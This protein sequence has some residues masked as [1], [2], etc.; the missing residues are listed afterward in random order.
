MAK[1]TG[2][3][4][5]RPKVEMAGRRFGL[6]VVVNHAG[7]EPSGEISWLCRCDCGKQFASPGS[8][9]RRGSTVSCGCKRR[10]G[11][12]PVHGGFGTPEYAVWAS[13]KSRCSDPDN[14]DYY[15]RG[16]TVCK[17]WDDSFESFLADMG[18]R[19]S[20]QHSIDRKDN[21]GNYEP[22]NCRWVTRK[23]QERN[24]RSN[25]ILTL[26]GKSQPIVV[27]SEELGIHQKLIACRLRRGWSEKD[28]LTVPLGGPR[29]MF[30]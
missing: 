30:A 1:P 7:V 25:R 10:R 11:K 5:G 4:T 8:R 14:R 2:M 23:E 13:I 19:P 22:G 17:R 20:K 3:P 18:K 15:G 26:N 6:A 29:E 12:A 24:K 9:L 28:A 21:N 16:I 27:W